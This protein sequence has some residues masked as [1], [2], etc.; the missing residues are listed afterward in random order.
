MLLLLV[1]LVHGTVARG[2]SCRGMV[3]IHRPWL[4]LQRLRILLVLRQMLAWCC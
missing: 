1:L 3:A 4:S 2:A